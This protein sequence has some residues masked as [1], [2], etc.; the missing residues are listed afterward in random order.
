MGSFTLR[1]VRLVQRTETRLRIRAATRQ[2]RPMNT[3][4][5]AYFAKEPVWRSPR[6]SW[7]T[8]RQLPAICTTQC[9]S[10][11]ASEQRACGGVLPNWLWSLRKT[12]NKAVTA[13][14]LLLGCTATRLYPARSVPGFPSTRCVSIT[15]AEPCH[16]SPSPLAS[17]QPLFRIKHQ[18]QQCGDEQRQL[19]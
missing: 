4:P 1:F 8:R 6:S 7:G 18:Q 3:M 14:C 13:S 2:K 19:P 9:V 12:E 11:E 10:V 15:K 5:Q 16:P 17:G